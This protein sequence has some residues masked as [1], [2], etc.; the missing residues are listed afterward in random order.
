MRQIGTVAFVQI[1]QDRLKE[2][3][4]P[5]RVY[6]PNPLLR[7]QRLLLTKEGIT[8]VTA[9]GE[10]LIDVHNTRHPR[11][12][13]RVE[14]SISLGFLQH[15]AELRDRFGAHM[16]DGVG[17][18]NI[19]V[20]AEVD[21]TP[22][23]LPQRLFIHNKADDNLIELVGVAPAPPCAEYSAFSARKTLSA[24]ELKQTLQFLDHGRRGYYATLVEKA[25]DCYVQ[26]GDTLLLADD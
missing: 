11:S 16:V 10:G 18:E 20:N 25:C 1:Q 23:M 9:E 26:A 14:N 7:V 5:N 17:G 24:P 13:N 2:G 21:V 3:Q 22:D 8:G 19:L 12:R 6:R 4:Q 15:Y